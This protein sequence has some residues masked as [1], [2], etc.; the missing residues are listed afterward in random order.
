MLDAGKLRVF[1]EI[2]LKESPGKKNPSFV[3]VKEQ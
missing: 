3:Y 2:G 1:N